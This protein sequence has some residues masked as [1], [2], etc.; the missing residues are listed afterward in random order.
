M[1]RSSQTPT[2]DL[3]QKEYVDQ[4]TRYHEELQRAW[5]AGERV[6]SIK[7]VIKCTKLLQDTTVPQFYPSVFIMVTEILDTFGKVVWNRILS[8]AEADE[9]GDKEPEVRAESIQR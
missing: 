4:L 9:G 2:L 1:L 6:L 5:K 8:K 7:I 3:T